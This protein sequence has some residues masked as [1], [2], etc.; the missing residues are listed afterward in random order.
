MFHIRSKIGLSTKAFSQSDL[1]TFLQK[2]KE[3][4]NQ[5][6]FGENISASL[7]KISVKLAASKK[8]TPLK[9]L[10]TINVIDSQKAELTT[11][12]PQVYSSDRYFFIY[13]F[14]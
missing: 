10:G 2:Y 13:C 11:F 9:D 4:I 14:S 5:I 3:S 12:D 6:S 1:K 8:D 7:E